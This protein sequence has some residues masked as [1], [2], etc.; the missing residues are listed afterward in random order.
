MYAIVKKVVT[1]PATSPNFEAAGVAEVLTAAIVPCL[2][3]ALCA[4]AGPAAF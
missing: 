2:A 4:T 1:P 3:V